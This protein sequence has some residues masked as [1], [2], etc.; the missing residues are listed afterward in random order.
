MSTDRSD[1]GHASA[2]ACM[3]GVGGVRHPSAASTSAW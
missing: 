1:R 2:A 3:G